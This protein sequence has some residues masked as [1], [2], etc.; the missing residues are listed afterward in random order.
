MAPDGAHHSASESRVSGV[1][2]QPYFSCDSS[3]RGAVERMNPRAFAR[4][5]RNGTIESR[6]SRDARGSPALPPL[7][8][9]GSSLLRIIALSC[10]GQQVRDGNGTDDN[11]IENDGY[12][13][14][15]R[16]TRCGAHRRT[17]VRL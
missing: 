14:W 2:E 7:E 6:S 17:A 3:D 16:H 15:C 8:G 9:N 11:S 4:S 5:F 12:A 1:P 10:S 13:L